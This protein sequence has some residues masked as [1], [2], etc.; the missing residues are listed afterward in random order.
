MP[1]KEQL[2]ELSDKLR[3]ELGITEEVSARGHLP[4]LLT[5]GEFRALYDALRLSA[6]QFSARFGVS[7]SSVAEWKRRPTSAGVYLREPAYSKLAP[8]IQRARELG[9]LA[10]DPGRPE[11]RRRAVHPTPRSRIRGGTA[12]VIEWR[13]TQCGESWRRS[14]LVDRGGD[15]VHPLPP[16]GPTTGF[17]G[18]VIPHDK[19]VRKPEE[20]AA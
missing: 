13:C 15:F 16:G 11:P 17:C 7:T 9:L 14:T 10:V 1:T 6:K 18:P 2:R 3:A 8:V 20:P 5:A 19:R 4:P 12:E